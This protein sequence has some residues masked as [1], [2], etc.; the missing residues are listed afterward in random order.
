[1]RLLRWEA[2]VSDPWMKVPCREAPEQWF[3]T[4]GESTARASS[5]RDAV[6]GCGRCELRA[7]CASA[8]LKS[9]AGVGIWA[10]VDL[11]DTGGKVPHWEKTE[12]LRRIAG[13][14]S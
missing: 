5:V 10:G 9:R 8:A 1:M 13:A 12:E 14:G 2:A 4:K 7:Q 3:P 6:A 11:G